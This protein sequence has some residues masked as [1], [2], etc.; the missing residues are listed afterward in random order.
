M[1]HTDTNAWRAL[2]QAI[3]EWKLLN[4][5]KLWCGEGDLNPHKLA[6]ASTSS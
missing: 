4:R 2:V 3:K 5:S 6:F 1:R